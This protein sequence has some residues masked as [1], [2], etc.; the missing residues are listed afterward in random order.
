MMGRVTP[1]PIPADA[2]RARMAVSALF[3]VN[4]ALIANVLPRLPVIKADLALSNTE[5]GAAVAA[6]PVG[7]L[8]AGGFAGLLIHRVGS[9]RLTVAT[10]VVFAVLL[11]WLG[12][13]PSW[14]ALAGGFLVLGALDATMDAAQNAH[15]VVVQRR[16][17]RSI[18]HSF[19]GWW[20]AG[21]LVGGAAGALAAGAA[22]PVPLHLALAGTVLAGITLVAWRGLLPG[23]DVDV[24]A[25]PAEDVAERVHLRNA[26]RLLGLLGPLALLGLLGVMLE[27]AA[28][29][30][31]TVYLN[32][33]L[34]VGA[35][36][37]A[38]A[39]VLYTAAMTVGR[40]TNDRWVDRWGGTLVVRAGALA[41]AAG[42]GLVMA[43]DPTGVPPLAYVGFVAVGLGAASMFPIMV[44][45]AARVPGVPPAHGIAIVSWL[46]RVG[47]VIAP[48]LVGVA[49]DA[50]GLAA[51][52]LIP[53]T[54]ALMMAV[55]A[56]ILLAK[57]RPAAPRTAVP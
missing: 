47:F 53:L 7:G 46:A 55:L 17:G 8:I 26:V 2:R 31:S 48:A 9:G 52:F 42:L 5:L 23:R 37:A 20:S 56:P 54:A 27:D 33:V 12:L 39:F 10:G 45:R 44:D 51:A 34:G 3:L 21:T 4:G 28:Q 41:A 49:A 25:A 29:T 35:G 6:M 38:V 13:A 22:I 50:Y 16:Y 36:L 24:V 40:L 1:P 57:A 43:A 14:I 19:H 30:W 32:E 11:T 18:L 15:G